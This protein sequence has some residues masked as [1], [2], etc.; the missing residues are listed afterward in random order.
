MSTSISDSPEMP[1]ED[2]LSFLSMSSH[3]F[4]LML[5]CLTAR[6]PLALQ[7]DQESTDRMLG[8]FGA[9][10]PGERGNT[11]TMQSPG[12]VYEV[13]SRLPSRRSW[14]ASP[15]GR[16]GRGA[17]EGRVGKTPYA[18]RRAR[19]IDHVRGVRSSRPDVTSWVLLRF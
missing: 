7:N 3:S 15:T 8:G 11:E 17:L 16:D 1:I 10:L 2:Q 6:R 4:C 5:L 12:I 14:F 9:H 13:V 18:E 19:G